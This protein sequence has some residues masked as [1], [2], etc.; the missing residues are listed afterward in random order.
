MLTSNTPG[1]AGEGHTPSGSRQATGNGRGEQTPRPGLLTHMGH[2][3]AF[4]EFKLGLTRLRDG[5]PAQALQHIQRAAQ[6]EQQNP[7]YLSYLGLLLALTRKRWAEAERLCTTA[8]RIKRTHPQLY[9]NLAEVYL[10]AGQRQEAIEALVLGLQYTNR[11]PS[12]LRTLERISMRRPPILPFL[13][14]ANVVNR[15]LGRLRHRM[16]Q[17]LDWA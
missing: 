1:R 10:A 5:F 13:P 15:M 6:L 16:L 4:E 12:L 7:F 11:H 9:L 14:R 8:L 3:V 2:T 17:W